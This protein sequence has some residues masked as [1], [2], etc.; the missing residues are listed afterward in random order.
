MASGNQDGQRAMNT[1]ERGGVFYRVWIGH[2]ARWIPHHWSD[3]PPQA[4]AVELADS[5]LLQRDAARQVVEGFNR[6]MLER[7]KQLWA[8]A[9]PVR[10]RIDGE[11]QRGQTI[12]CVGRRNVTVYPIAAYPI[13]R[14]SSSHPNV[15]DRR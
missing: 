14:G 12:H 9:V 7:E 10:V 4:E 11:P 2:Y 1:I 8:I 3:V 13:T 15:R 6:R 5:R